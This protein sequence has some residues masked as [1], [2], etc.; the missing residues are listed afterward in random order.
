MARK[1][2]FTADFTIITDS[3]EQ[4]P[5]LFTG[6][7]KRKNY[8]DYPLTVPTRSQTLST[9]DY[10]ILGLESAITIE[11][12]SA[13]DLVSTITAHRERFERELTRMQ[14]MDFSAVIVEATWQ[15]TQSYC[16]IST[17][18]NPA[19]LD[20]SILTFQM[21]YPRTHW[22]YRPSRFYAMK[23]A[24]KLFDIYLRRIKKVKNAK[25]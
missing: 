8:I 4:N 9:G 22:Y 21:R 25:Q 18:M 5:W 7:T 6:L 19:A 2:T 23:T 15:Y 1:K 24:Y 12:K 13:S 20:A 14:E 11:R 17:D 16:H 10:S 3:R